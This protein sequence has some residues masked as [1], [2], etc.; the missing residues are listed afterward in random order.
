MKK[1]KLLKSRGFDRNGH[2]HEL[3]REK[4]RGSFYYIRIKLYGT[5]DFCVEKMLFRHG[6]KTKLYTDMTWHRAP[7]QKHKNVHEMGRH[8]SKFTFNRGV[9]R[10]STRYGRWWRFRAK[11]IF[12]Q[13]LIFLI[14]FTEMFREK[15][16]LYF[17]RP[18]CH[19]GGEGGKQT[20]HMIL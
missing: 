6:K 15:Y 20:N 7:P 18:S 10:I 17:F 11:I 8:S 16:F 2:H 4:L 19:P 9:L 5:H 14:F 12:L 3:S 1:K 13:I